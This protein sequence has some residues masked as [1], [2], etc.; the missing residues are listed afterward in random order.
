MRLF[1]L[2]LYFFNLSVVFAQTKQSGIVSSSYTYKHFIIADG[3]PQIQITALFCDSNG[4]VWVGTKFGVARWNGKQFKVFTPKEGAAGRQVTQ[5][6]QAATGEIIVAF[7]AP[8]FNI[9]RGDAIE[10]VHLPAHW[11]AINISAVFKEKGSRIFLH[12]YTNIGENGTPKMLI[13]IYNL[14]TRRFEREIWM[15]FANILTITND[16]YIITTEFDGLEKKVN[17]CDLYQY[18]NFIKRVKAPGMFTGFN[19]ASRPYN[20]FYVNN[21]LTTIWEAHLKDNSVEFISRPSLVNEQLSKLRAQYVFA[22]PAGNT[23]YQNEQQQI[24]EQSAAGKKVL[25][26]LPASNSMILDKENNLWEA[27]EN[28]LFCFYKMAMQEYRFNVLPGTMDAV[29]SMVR[30]ENGTWYYG[31]YELGFWTSTNNN[32]TWQRIAAIDKN[33]ANQHMKK[34]S[35]GSIV[36]KN[37]AVVLSTAAGFYYI[38]GPVFQQYNLYGK[39]A[40]VFSCWEDTLNNRVLIS[41]YNHL[42]S[43]NLQTLQLDTLFTTP[44]KGLHT[45]LNITSNS[46]H[47][48]ILTGRG[49]PLQYKE[50]KWQP[51]TG[52]TE[53]RS[54]SS[55]VDAWDGLWLGEPQQLTVVRNGKAQRMQ[56]FPGRQLVLSLTVWNKKWL[57]IGGGFEIIFLDLETYYQTGKEMYQRFDAGSGF[58]TTE[59]GQNSFV[60]DADSSIWWPCQD[61]VIRFWPRQL[62]G[63]TV[64]ANN[65]VIF[66]T[67]ISN[68]KDSSISISD[69]YK[70]KRFLSPSNF[71]KLHFAFG[72]AAMN[73]HDNLVYRYKLRGI[74]NQ[75]SPPSSDAYAVFNNLLPGTYQ[76][77]VQS[78]LDKFNWSGVT[79]SLSIKIPAYWYETKV[80]KLLGITAGVS[81]IAFVTL[82][83][84][85]RKRAGLERQKLMNELQLKAI[86]SKALPHFSGNAFAN[87]DYYI[88]KGDT[89][90][91]TKY[92]AIL[93]RLHNITL[94]DSD[95]AARTLDEEVTYVKLYLEMEKLRFEAHLNYSVEVGEGVNSETMV[96]VMVLHTFA[97]NAIKHGIKNKQE[98]GCVQ[99]SAVNSGNGVSL[100][101]ADD[102]IGREAAKQFHDS[103]KQGL[104]ILHQQI[105]LY[106]S[107]NREKITLHVEDL[108]NAKGVAAGTI[109]SI[110]IPANYNF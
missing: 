101:V 14:Q 68:Q 38:N 108:K 30:A 62:L 79:K 105:D 56:H 19:H 33:A 39:G 47:Q 73:N 71:R 97:E 34:G 32:Q 104:A 80:A 92:L 9:L 50:G 107:R 58:I 5:I 37:G 78:S 4:F 86:R 90:N 40:E 91:A 44:Y 81:L 12:C 23:Y 110:Y 70:N 96:P 8:A 24:I 60:H 109:F 106:N 52:A 76:L 64:A 22:S 18:N 99:V 84:A 3:L 43:L 13:A 2:L 46:N 65:P 67:I 72:A 57:V 61:K 28:G 88:E 85:K 21:D 54:I 1:L 94:T 100:R 75:W 29:W 63:T 27:T 69:T 15:P 93:S 11:K 77:E 48:P 41:K 95:K 66:S 98:P 31:S 102:G 20:H 87:I 16:G 26:R 103:T 55:F 36:L 17:T 49:I 59:G 42:F 35:F 82:G 53:V 83:F 74:S 51:V 7:N 89:E 45:I 25:A 10:T 6:A